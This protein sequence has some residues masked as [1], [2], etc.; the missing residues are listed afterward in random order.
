MFEVLIKPS[1]FEFLFKPN[2]MEHILLGSVVLSYNDWPDV[3]W[4]TMNS[5]QL[6][7]DSSN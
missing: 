4:D 6:I 7:L 5:T 1:S 3:S 2:V